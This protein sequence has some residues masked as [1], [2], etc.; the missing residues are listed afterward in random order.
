MD[1]G[2]SKARR[3]KSRDEKRERFNAGGQHLPLKCL[4]SLSSIAIDH[5]R[6]ARPARHRPKP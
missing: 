4:C 3:G 6:K 5:S 1:D 2:D